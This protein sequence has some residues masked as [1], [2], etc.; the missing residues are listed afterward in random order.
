MYPNRIFSDCTTLVDLMYE[1]DPL[2]TWRYK[3]LLE[4]IRSHIISCN[5]A[6]VE[7]IP[8]HLNRV[9]DKL[10]KFALRNPAV[11][12]FHKGWSFQ[13]GWPKRSRPVI[14]SFKES[15]S[16]VFLFFSC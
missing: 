12:L 4:K 9:V 6:K 16:C 14:S 2:A 1:D 7:Y 3:E 11:M 13:N 10:G 15:R 5:D 8:R